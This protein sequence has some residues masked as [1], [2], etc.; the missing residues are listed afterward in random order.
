VTTYDAPRA[1]GPVETPRAEGRPPGSGA[2]FDERGFRWPDP[3]GNPKRE[4]K[5]PWFHFHD[6]HEARDYLSSLAVMQV[7]GILLL[8]NGVFIKNPRFGW[9]VFLGL[10]V[11]QVVHRRIWYDLCKRAV[12]PPARYH[13]WTIG[14][15]NLR[16]W[17][18]VAQ[19]RAMLQD[20]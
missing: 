18:C 14:V 13:R 3:P 15:G 16:M 9:P 6:V 10:L 19:A 17:Q 12:P 2:L 20:R 5:L 8:I 11:V 4:A 1:D 7:L